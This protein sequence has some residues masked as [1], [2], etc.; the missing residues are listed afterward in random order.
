M[1]NL[2][3]LH[4]Q[5]ATLARLGLPERPYP[6][7]A[8][9]LPE[10]LEA[11]TDTLPLA[12]LLFGLQCATEDGESDWAEAEPALRRL[13]ELIAPED[14]L[15]ERVTA[16]GET[17]AIEIGPVDLDGPLVTL[18]RGMTLI[19]AFQPRPEGGLR[20]AV[21][22]SLCA[23]GARWVTL[24][25]TNPDAEGR[26]QGFDSGWD[27]GLAQVGRFAQALASD[28]GE[29]YLSG[30]TRGLGI[31]DDGRTL[32]DWRVQ[33]ELLPRRPAEVAVQLGVWW[34][35]HED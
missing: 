27:C 11:E 10:L 29:T 32:P 9:L 7:R 33:A 1:P 8:D 34:A 18:Q 23:H 21:Y 5:P 26:V 4:L 16:R 24:L 30:W 19:A 13:A 15:R 6:V 20:V 31:T 2:A 22:Q 12:E 28:R 14:D 25:G 17:W 35:L 3:D